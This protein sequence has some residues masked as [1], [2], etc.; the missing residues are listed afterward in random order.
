M[1]TL[2]YSPSATEDEARTAILRPSGLDGAALDEWMASPIPSYQ[3]ASFVEAGIELDEALALHAAGIGGTATLLATRIGLSPWEI[4]D[5]CVDGFGMG[6]LHALVTG[7]ATLQLVDE[8]RSRDLSSTA[9]LAAL[10][11]GIAAKDVA[12]LLEALDAIGDLVEPGNAA[13]LVIE[14]EVWRAWTQ[15]AGDCDE[16]SLHRL[17]AWASRGFGPYEAVAW[18]LVQIDPALAATAVAGD[19][20]PLDVVIFQDRW[21]PVEREVI[22]RMT[23]RGARWVTLSGQTLPRRVGDAIEQFGGTDVDIASLLRAFGYHVESRR[24]SAANAISP[25]GQR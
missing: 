2:T 20:C 9:C 8:W 14:P 19:L 10:R 15:L 6:T 22:Q 7:G 3:A 25:R 21:A 5:R 17:Q 13:G 12:V 24:G 23:P 1:S 16:T 11:E 4:P 18:A